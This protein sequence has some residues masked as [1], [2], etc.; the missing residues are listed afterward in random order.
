MNNGKID[1][2][3]IFIEARLVEKD[4]IKPLLIDGGFIKE[5]DLK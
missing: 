2:P 1:V 5:E 4:D 3:S